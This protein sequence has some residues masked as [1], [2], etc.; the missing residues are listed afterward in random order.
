MID[1]VL[2]YL[3]RFY[4]LG[5]ELSCLSNFWLAPRNHLLAHLDYFSRTLFFFLDILS[6]LS[7][8]SFFVFDLQYYMNSKLT[9]C[10]RLSSCCCRSRFSASH[11]STT[12]CFFWIC[13]TNDWFSCVLISSVNFVAYWMA[14]IDCSKYLV[15]GFTL[16]FKSSAVTVITSISV[17]R[18]SSIF[19]CL[20][21]NYLKSSSF[22]SLSFNCSGD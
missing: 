19:F 22:F 3:C 12:A 17:I 4:L 8:L 21:W 13:S 20:S 11:T 10:N 14:S 15:S 1:L 2:N 18:S 16:T 7:L 5:V 9:C 6:N